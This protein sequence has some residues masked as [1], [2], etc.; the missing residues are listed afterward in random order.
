MSAYCNFVSQLEI[1]HLHRIYHDNAYGFPIKEDNELFGRL[2]LEI[3]QAGLS[4]TTILK[5]S[6]ISERPIM[7]STKKKIASYKEKDRERLLNDAGII[8][9]RLKVDAAI[10]NAKTVLSI[11]KEFGSFKAWLD[12]HHPLNKA[13]WTKLF[14]K[15][16]RFTG[17]EI[18]NE[19][20]VSTGYL[21][22]AHHENCP[23]FKKTVKAKPAWMQL[24]KTK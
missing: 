18:V 1:D 23:V 8:R 14:K 5:K 7:P 2:I 10:E 20:L 3:N 24:K 21:P 4:W 17:G 6:K 22:Q 19:F 13:E 12:H 15:T 9:N 11:Q 16:F